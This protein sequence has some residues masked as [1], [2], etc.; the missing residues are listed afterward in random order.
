[1]FMSCY[2]DILAFVCCLKIDLKVGTKMLQSIL[3]NLG[4]LVGL[5]GRAILEILKNLK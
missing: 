2:A 5:Y 3:F 4:N 1:M